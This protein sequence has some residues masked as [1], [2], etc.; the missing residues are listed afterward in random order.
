MDD[1][2]D[3]Q[4]GSDDWFVA[5]LVPVESRLYRY[6]AS[7]APVR[8]DAEDLFQKSLLTAWQER[9]RFQTGGDLFAWLCGIARNHVRHHYRALQ[10]SR[11]VFDQEVVEQ[12]AA[13]LL[14]ED[15]HFQHR[16]AALTECLEKLSPQQRELVEQYYQSEGTIRDFA[17]LRGLA[18]ETL[19][20]RLQRIRAVL[21]DCITATL[22]REANA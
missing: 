9:R 7:L 21:E 1:E 22:A 8:A 4:S 20:K 16:Q 3:P 11:V 19:Y 13:R 10:R 18:V 15:R 12:L 17:Q 14:E 6:I 2:T 5:A